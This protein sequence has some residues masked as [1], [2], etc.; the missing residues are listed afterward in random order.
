MWM[1]CS[2]APLLRSLSSFHGL[3][4]IATAGQRPMRAMRRHRPD[5]KTGL[6]GLAYLLLPKHI[7]STKLGQVSALD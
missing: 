7:T 4:D 5:G 1:P 6:D 2:A 3:K